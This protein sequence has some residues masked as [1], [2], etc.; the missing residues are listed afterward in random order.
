MRSIDFPHNK[1]YNRITTKKAGNI[2]ANNKLTKIQEEQVCC[3]RKMEVYKHNDMIQKGRHELTLQEQ[4]CVL[5]A[6]SKI[7]PNDTVFQEY[8]FELSDFYKLCGIHGDSYTK[9]KKILQ[10]LADRSWWATIDEKGTE[11]LVRW[12]STLRTSKRSGKVT[13]EF[14][15]D[16]MPFLLELT[17]ENQ[18]YTHY[19]MKYIL[20]MKSQYAI[21]LYELLKSYQRNNYQWFFNIEQLKKQLNGEKYTRFP[22][23][24]RWA[25]EPAVKEINK[26]T[27]IN[28]AWEPIKEGRK[29]IRII[30]Y[31]I[32][33]KKNA[34]LE[35][36]KSITEALDGPI[37]ILSLIQKKTNS[38]KSQFFREN[39][40]EK[41][42]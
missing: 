7:K 23:F 5:Y 35:T 6:I 14:H 32:G 28:I 13:I 2:M 42:K 20:P 27:D 38:V 39:L 26:F 16:M 4:R 19:Q 36:E 8:T 33:K 22:D 3:S 12:F 29:V 18:Y 1:S 24:R 34:L 21:R 41:N 15:K 10:G 17:K 30:F 25:I 11:S 9:L 40:G 31:M 37:D